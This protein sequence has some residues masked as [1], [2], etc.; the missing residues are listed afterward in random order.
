MRDLPVPPYDLALNTTMQTV[1]TV[2]LWAGTIA[3]L[4]YAY[5]LARQERSFFPLLLVLAVAVGSLIE[6][7]YDIAYHLFWL[8]NGQQWTLFTAF[9]LPQPVWVM[10][11]YVMVF[12]LP[13]LLLYRRLMAG[14]P[15]ALAFKFG[16]LLS[17]TTAVF[18]IIAIN[19]D[20][21][22][23]YGEAPI[24]LFG[25]PLWI[26]FMEG[27]QIASY[28][29]LAAVLRHRATLPAHGHAGP[30]DAGDVAHR[31]DQRRLLRHLAVVDHPAPQPRAGAGIC[32]RRDTPRHRRVAS[33][34]RRPLRAQ[35]RSSNASTCRGRTT[36]KW[37]RSNV[38]S[39]CSPS[40]SAVATTE[41]STPPSGR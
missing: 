34:L 31:P 5:R 20:L 41:A 9:G 35:G 27:G 24:R 18:E 15:V 19:I 33:I 21:Y 7:L 14:A 11:A 28:A 32:A 30:V 13:A 22:T 2:V 26:G 12:A 29:V 4:V 37:R 10:P 17:F 38:A 39:W 40:L 23:Y 16:L 8:D 25:Y 36:E 1:A 6:P 3:L